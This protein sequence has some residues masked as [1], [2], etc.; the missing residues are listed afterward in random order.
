MTRPGLSGIKRKLDLPTSR[1]M[2][3]T[4]FRGDLK[5]LT[6]TA[7]LAAV[8]TVFRAIPISKLIGISG[9]ITAAGMVAP[10]I[11]ILLEPAYGIAAVFAGTMIASLFPSNT[12]NFYGLGF[13]PGAVNVALVSL[14]VRGRRVEATLIFLVVIGLFLVN[15]FTIL[16]V[17]TQYLSPPIPYLWLH[18]IALLVLISPLSRNLAQRVTSTNYRR[19]FTGLVVVAFTGTMI[20]HLTGGILFAAVVGHTALAFWPA[21]FLAYPVERAILVLGAVLICTPVLGVLRATVRERVT[22]R[23][24][25]KASENSGVG[26]VGSND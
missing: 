17:G 1:P 14:A 9:T 3:Q 5:K 19:L 25:L 20:E 24:A 4:A 10:I 18:L 11:G 15:P 16:F 7:S 2:F 8:Y 6:L 21:I 12:V 13:L 22:P 26:S 23:L